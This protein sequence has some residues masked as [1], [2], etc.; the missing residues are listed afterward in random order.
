MYVTS[1]PYVYKHPFTYILFTICL[2]YCI[3]TPSL[4]EWQLPAVLIDRLLPA[5]MGPAR[6]AATV[7]SARYVIQRVYYMYAYV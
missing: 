2:T 5:H 4:I 3:H 7:Y 1:S 6:G